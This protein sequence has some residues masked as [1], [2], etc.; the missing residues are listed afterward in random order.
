[1][2]KRLRNQKASHQPMTG[3]FIFE[4]PRPFTAFRFPGTPSISE[5]STGGGVYRSALASIWRMRSR[6]TAKR[7]RHKMDMV[8]HEILFHFYH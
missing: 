7:R 5:T 2:P 6:V 1:M 8:G 3:L 4:S